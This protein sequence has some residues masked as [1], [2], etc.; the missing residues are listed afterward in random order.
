M[1]LSIEIDFTV[2]EIV[3][4]V[5]KQITADWYHTRENRPYH[6]FIYLQNGCIRYR[7]ANENVRIEVDELLY[8]EKGSSYILTSESDERPEYIIVNFQIEEPSDGEYSLAELLER[9][10][11][12]QDKLAMADRFGRLNDLYFYMPI[13]YRLELRAQLYSILGMALRASVIKNVTGNEHRLLPAVQRIREI[14]DQPYDI[15]ALAGL[16]GLS[17][18]H[19][20]KLFRDHFRMS[21]R[22]YILALRIDRAKSLLIQSDL[23]VSVIAERTGFGD[24]AYFCKMFRESTGQTPR[25]FRE[26]NG[27]YR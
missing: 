7:D 25:A 19:F 10:I 1:P 18:S 15:T 11:V 24:D 9:R 2:S 22:D 4:I 17:A 13:G 27:E 3:N 6:G 26:K 23:P 21:P 5:D 12:P 14:F 8:L 20:R 16:C